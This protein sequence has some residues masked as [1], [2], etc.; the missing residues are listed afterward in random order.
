MNKE[1][2]YRYAVDDTGE[3]VH[4]STVNE[5]N[6]HA[7]YR[8][9]SCGGVL[10]PV[11]GKKNAHHFRHK[12]DECSYESYIHQLWKQYVFDYWNKTQHW[13][14]TYYVEFS[15]AKVSSCGLNKANNNL[16]CNDNRFTESID[17]KGKYDTC[18]IEGSYGG[19]RADLLLSNSNNPEIIPTFVEI[20]YKHPCDEQ[21]QNSGIPIIEIIVKDDNLH[22]PQNFIE[23]PAIIPGQSNNNVGG[24]VF[25][26]YGF[27]RVRRPTHDVRRFSVYQDECGVVH[28]KVDDETISCHSIGTHLPNSMME[29]FV[30]ETAIN[31]N[32]S[33]FEYGIGVAAKYGIEIKHCRRCRFYGSRGRPCQVNLVV[34]K[35][36]IPVNINDFGDTELD[37]TNYAYMCSGYRVNEKNFFDK[38]I[39]CAVWR[40]EEYIDKPAQKKIDVKFFDV[41]IDRLRELSKL[42]KTG[43]LK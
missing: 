40:N 12:T 9:I 43:E 32:F 42:I 41:T 36:S 5:T 17:L 27:D 11:L 14:V 6:R 4:V 7:G 28:G 33:L 25:I 39:K 13:G 37:K 10:I 24:L 16:C 22:L 1:G 31:K 38:H 29:I 23:S 20:C 26:L 2:F 35:E 30:L 15:C 19:Y 34:N 21:K 3:T 18:T 8:C